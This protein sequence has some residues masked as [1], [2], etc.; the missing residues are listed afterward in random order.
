[1]WKNVAMVHVDEVD[2]IDVSTFQRDAVGYQQGEDDDGLFFEKPSGLD[3]N[4]LWLPFTEEE[5][6]LSQDLLAE[7]DSLADQFEVD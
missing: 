1:M 6:V 5:P 7:M 3:D 4:T 2:E